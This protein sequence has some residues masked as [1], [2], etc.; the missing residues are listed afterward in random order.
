[1]GGGRAFCLIFCVLILT[2]YSIESYPLRIAQ[3]SLN[4]IPKFY[5]ISLKKFINLTDRKSKKFC[6]IFQQRFATVT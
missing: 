1:M 6:F 5:S 3:P 2:G 4:I